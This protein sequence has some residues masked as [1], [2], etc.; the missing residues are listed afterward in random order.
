MYSVFLRFKF[1]GEVVLIVNRVRLIEESYNF[2]F[3]NDFF[4]FCSI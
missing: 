4:Q 2:V 3:C 1:Q